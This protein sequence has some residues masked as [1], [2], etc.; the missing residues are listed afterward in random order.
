M[1]AEWLHPDGHSG[2]NCSSDFVFLTAHS[3]L[4]R[5]STC[6]LDSV[7][8]NDVKTAFQIQEEADIY[9]AGDSVASLVNRAQCSETCILFSGCIVE[10]TAKR[11]NN[12][13]KLN[14]HKSNCE[15]KVESDETCPS[16][17]GGKAE[18][19]MTPQDSCTSSQC[20][21]WRNS[22]C[23]GGTAFGGL[24]VWSVSGE[25]VE[26]RTLPTHLVQAHKVRVFINL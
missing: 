6:S 23:V 9:K 24:L 17:L 26:S 22:A 3:A 15:E 16:S 5:Y 11:S 10:D 19:A 21:R 25:M 1:A 14:Q 2:Q 7:L 18:P 8:E 13:W 20:W 4:L 12:S